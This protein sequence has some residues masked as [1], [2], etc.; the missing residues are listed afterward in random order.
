MLYCSKN[1]DITGPL[2]DEP[3]TIEDFAKRYQKVRDSL[4]RLQPNGRP[5]HEE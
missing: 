5:P 3:R 2:D 4:K 1:A